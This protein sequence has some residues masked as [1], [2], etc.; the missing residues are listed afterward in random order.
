LHG[1]RD[2]MNSTRTRASVLGI[3][4]AWT[5]GN[6]SGVALITQ[7]ARR[8]HCVRVSHS[9]PS[10]ANGDPASQRL[11]VELLLN[12]CRDLLDG[13]PP[14]VVAVD[15][16]I[17]TK[18]I[19]A[20]R[21]ADREV[22]QRFGHAGCSTHSPT[23]TRPGEVST[24]F[25]S[26]FEKAGFRCNF[27][28][29]AQENSM[30]EVYPHV[31]LLALASSV[32]RLPYKAEKTDKYWPDVLIEERRRNLLAQWV[33]ILDLLGEH[34]HAIALALPSAEHTSF[35]AL[36]SHEDQ[37]DALVCAWVGA[38]YVEGKATA[39]GDDDS[40]IWIPTAALQQ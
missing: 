6:A 29:S 1:S 39:L 13:V 10:F 26:Q 7:K 25:V 16:P 15:M 40:A 28:P 31:A 8:W 34:I 20:R 3:D 21:A 22:S 19:E 30:I 27:G 9:Y 18:R 23:P 11:N 24:D 2:A 5:P 36:K 4:A 12:K 17:G 14:R 38:L 33:R 32:F 35:S 37:I